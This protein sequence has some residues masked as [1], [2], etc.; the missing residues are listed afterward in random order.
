MSKNLSLNVEEMEQYLVDNYQ[1]EILGHTGIHY[2]FRFPN[3]YGVSVVKSYGSYGWEEDK[4]EIA[5]LLF[6][7]ETDVL[8]STE[9]IIVRPEQIVKGDDVL[10]NLT[11]TQVKEILQKV[12]NL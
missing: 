9:W 8:K 1:D 10:G 4:W 5:I 12:Q 7:E 3:G 6:D 11:D 2:I